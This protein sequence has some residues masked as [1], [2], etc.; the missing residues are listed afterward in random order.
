MTKRLSIVPG[1]H[2]MYAEHLI[3]NFEGKWNHGNH[4]LLSVSQVP[5]GQGRIATNA[6][7]FDVYPGEFSNTEIGEAGLLP[8]CAFFSSLSA[9]LS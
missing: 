9:S 2:V 8:T 4:T 3:E 5:E 1:Y 7:R 6:F